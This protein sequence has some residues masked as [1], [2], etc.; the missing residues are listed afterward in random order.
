MYLILVFYNHSCFQGKL[1]PKLP[2]VCTWFIK[3]R[4]LLESKDFIFSFA[5]YSVLSLRFSYSELCFRYIVVPLFMAVESC[6]YIF[7]LFILFWVVLLS[8]VES[9]KVCKV[10]WHFPLNSLCN[11]TI[12][13]VFPAWFIVCTLVTMQCYAISVQVNQMTTIAFVYHSR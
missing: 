10:L 1:C 7:K 3:F 2:G 9:G 8:F 11:S 5:K 4:I 12:N 6:F 13:P